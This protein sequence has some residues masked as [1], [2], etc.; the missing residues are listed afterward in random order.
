VVRRGERACRQ[1][2]T[3]RRRDAVAAGWGLRFGGLGLA[4]A[5]AAP[6]EV[7]ARVRLAPPAATGP[8]SLEEALQRRRSV[9]GFARWPIG[10]ADIGQL[11][12]A[13]QGITQAQGLR[14]AP[15]AGA[16]YPL[17]IHLV[18]GDVSGL[19][20]GVY[21]YEPPGHVLVRTDAGDA[22][23]A[24]RSAVGGQG[25]IGDAPAVLAIAAVGAR[26][27]GKYGERAAR[28]VC[29]EAGHAAQNVQLQATARGCASVFVG[30][31]DDA[32]LHSALRLPAEQ[33]PLGLVAVG[34]AR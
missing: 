19:A 27:A 26:S 15:S 33:T 8:L 14:T 3:V 31:F 18:V 13:A 4:A 24:L 5:A 7:G 22:R 6:P 2:F 1:G 17:E 16:L 20:S 29:L 11:L 21:R 23:A 25:W 30:A 9:R 28:Y 10:L 12:W 32:R 34:W